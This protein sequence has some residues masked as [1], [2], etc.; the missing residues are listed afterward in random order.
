MGYTHNFNS[1]ESSR[2]LSVTESETN[3][4]SGWSIGDFEKARKSVATEVS[5][6]I[7]AGVAG[8]NPEIQILNKRDGNRTKSGKFVSGWESPMIKEIAFQ[9]KNSSKIQ[10]LKSHISHY[11]V[12]VT[13]QDRLEGSYNPERSA[14]FVE[15]KG[16]TFIIDFGF[17]SS[18]WEKLKENRDLFD[19]RLFVTFAPLQVIDATP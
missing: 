14:A 17:R 3:D 10:L 6:I 9:C 5:D 7:C 12:L 1:R 15:Q 18:I 4:Y 13:E 16:N 19:A 11:S 8:D 2:E